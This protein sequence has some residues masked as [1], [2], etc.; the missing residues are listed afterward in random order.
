MEFIEHNAS[1]KVLKAY[2]RNIF[3]C[4][5]CGNLSGG[6]NAGSFLGRLRG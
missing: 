3:N 6:M 5:F 4:R 2:C 1:G